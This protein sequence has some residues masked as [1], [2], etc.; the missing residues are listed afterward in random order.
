MAQSPGGQAIQPDGAGGDGEIAKSPNRRITKWGEGGGG[1]GDVAVLIPA[2]DCAATVGEVVRGAREILPTVVVVNDGSKDETAARAAAAGA[3]VL[4]HAVT[5]GKGAA[6]MTGMAWLNER[7]AAR[8]VTMD[9]DGQHLAGEIEKLLQM[10]ASEPSALIV[11]ARRIE[12]AVSSARL[13]GN[14][15][16]NRWVEIACGQALPDTQ[17]GFRLYP[18]RDTLALGVRARHFGFETEVLIRA[19]RAGIPIRSVPVRVY[20]P[21]V[22]Q[23][24]SHFRPFVDTVRIIL[25]VLGLIFRI[26]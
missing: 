3:T 8:V 12:T 4:D 9:G 22:A 24:V 18:L 25:V 15:F 1:L 7:G 17:S 26:W 6:L 20:Y 14:R 5:R 13:F 11:G 2:L 19:A 16:A 21:P 10:S 23:R